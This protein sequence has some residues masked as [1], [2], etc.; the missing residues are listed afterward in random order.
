MP[1]CQYDSKN[2]AP[3]DWLMSKGKRRTFIPHG[4][5][6]VDGAAEDGDEEETP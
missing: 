4:Y 3:D 2:D 6:C 1:V 5:M